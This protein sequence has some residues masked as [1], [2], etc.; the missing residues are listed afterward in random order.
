VQTPFAIL[1][2]FYRVSVPWW[3]GDAHVGYRVDTKA[4]RHRT[5]SRDSAAPD[6][7]NSEALPSDVNLEHAN[8]RP[9]SQGSESQILN[10]LV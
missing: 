8:C 9:E 3:T 1:L 6:S 5:H 2:A 10:T 4:E 7:F